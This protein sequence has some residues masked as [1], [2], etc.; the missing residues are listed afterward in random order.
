MA[1]RETFI[2]NAIG[3]LCVLWE[4]VCRGMGMGCGTQ[5]SIQR[6]VLI[7]RRLAPS[8][9]SRFMS[10]PDANS[11]A[12]RSE[13]RSRSSACGDQGMPRFEVHP[14]YSDALAAIGWTSV[15]AVMSATQ[16]VSSWRRRDQRENA[17]IELT[18]GDGAAVLAHLK[19]HREAQ[20]PASGVT[21]HLAIKACEQAGVSTMTAIASGSQEGTADSVEL[22]AVESFLL[23]LDIAGADEADVLWRR[24]E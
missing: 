20:L 19:R 9:H 12:H 23:T 17:R 16:G 11:N 3:D 7:D 13:D 22:K 10:E 15:D 4:V 24:Q 5:V 18:L 6:S 8:L 21:E 1:D 2:L 14:D